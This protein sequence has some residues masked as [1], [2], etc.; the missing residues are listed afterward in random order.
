MCAD[1]PLILFKTQRG[2]RQPRPSQKSNVVL[3]SKLG[4]GKLAIG[5]CGK[6]REIFSYVHDGNSRGPPSKGWLVIPRPIYNEGEGRR[7]G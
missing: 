4:Q 5:E 6:L 7:A 1:P 2:G 3:P